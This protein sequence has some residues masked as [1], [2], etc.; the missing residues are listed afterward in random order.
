MNKREM[1]ESLIEAQ[2]KLNVIYMNL[3][4]YDDPQAGID[5]VTVQDIIR[6]DIGAVKY[7]LQNE[8]EHEEMFAEK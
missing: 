4:E 2:R 7:A 3:K 8:V 6:E 1:L 5:R